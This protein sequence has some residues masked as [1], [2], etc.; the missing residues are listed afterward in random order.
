MLDAVPRPDAHDV[1]EHHLGGGETGCRPHAHRHTAVI[2]I[3]T[4]LLMHVKICCKRV[5]H[6]M[7]A[8]LYK[9]TLLSCALPLLHGA[10]VLY[11]RDWDSLYSLLFEEHLAKVKDQ[12]AAA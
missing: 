3:L 4:Y 6:M 7:R 2:V 11:A 10:S 12:H 1:G 5:V 9:H 8:M